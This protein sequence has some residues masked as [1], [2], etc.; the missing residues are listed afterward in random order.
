MQLVG[1]ASGACLLASPS[2]ADEGGLVHYAVPALQ[3]FTP[4]VE[5]WIANSQNGLIHRCQEIEK[6]TNPLAGGPQCVGEDGEVGRAP[7]ACCRRGRSITRLQPY[8]LLVCMCGPQPYAKLSSPGACPGSIPCSSRHQT[9]MW[10]L[11][12]VWE[13]KL[14]FSSCAAH[15]SIVSRH[16][17]CCRAQPHCSCGGRDAAAHPWGGPAV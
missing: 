13:H 12:N 6:S 15:G 11:C 17:H 16:L 1:A 8:Y 4:H 9:S 5:R 14:T 3:I 2:Y 10:R 7:Q